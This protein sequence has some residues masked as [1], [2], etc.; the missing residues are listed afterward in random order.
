MY[1]SSLSSSAYR[2][3]FTSPLVSYEIVNNYSLLI[4]VQGSDPSLTPY[5]IASHLDVVPAIPDLWDTPPFKGT[6]QDG[7]I[8]GRGT[9]DC[10]NGVM[11]SIVFSLDNAW[12]LS[13]ELF[14]TNISCVIF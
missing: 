10:K 11:V 1:N 6:V 5:M 9:L 3:I 4:H 2:P 14:F 7:Y 13:I 12:A 8:Y